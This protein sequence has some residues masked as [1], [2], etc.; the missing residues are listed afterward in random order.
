MKDIWYEQDSSE[1][2]PT[3]STIDT[4]PEVGSVAFMHG[5]IQEGWS[6]KT[7]HHNIHLVT[8]AEIFGWSRSEP[9]RRISQRKTAATPQ[10]ADYMSWEDGNFVVHVDYG[11]G[12]FVGM[13]HRIVD[14]NEREYL[15][16][17][18]HGTDTL[19]VPIHQADRLTNTLA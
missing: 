12:K 11:I 19:F 9:R 18:Y 15:L 5:A 17:E 4:I 3:L 16:V 2:I 1:F 7:D 14:G 6:L 8:D 10:A 13:R